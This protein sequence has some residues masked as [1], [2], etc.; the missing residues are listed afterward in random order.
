MAEPLLRIDRVCKRFGG[1]LAVDHASLAV[2]AGR[3]TALIGPNGAGK[4]T[5]FSIISGFLPPSEGRIFH[6]G[7]DITGMP[8]HLLARRGIVRTFQIA[9]P[10]AGLTVHENIAIGAHLSR[11][12]RADALDAAAEVANTVGL[13]DVLGRPAASLTVAGRKR[14]EVARALAAGPELLLLDEVLAGLNPGE[15]AAMVP[16]IRALADDGI[17]IVMIEHVMQAV[18][19]LAEHVFVLAEGRIIADGTPQTV[20]GSPRVVEAYLGHGA[21]ARLS[22][23]GGAHV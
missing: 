21:A 10:F 9:Q 7:V 1:L 6:R 8:P 5:L 4:T 22:A 20:V 11:R 18:M 16:V 14:L 2:D 19:S 17:T 15:I 23:A 13:G 12:S 3:I